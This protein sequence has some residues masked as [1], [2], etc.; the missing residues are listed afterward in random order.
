MVIV[1]LSA[2]RGQNVKDILLQ[3]PAFAG[4]STEVYVDQSSVD[5]TIIEYMS[6]RSSGVDVRNSGMVLP[7]VQPMISCSGWSK[8]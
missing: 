5:G 2:Q 8:V 1:I 6:L 7:T 3:A 4:N